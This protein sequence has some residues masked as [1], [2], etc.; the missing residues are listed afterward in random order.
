MSSPLSNPLRWTDLDLEPIY[1]LINRALAEDGTGLGLRK[2]QPSFF[3]PSTEMIGSTEKT[4]TASLVARQDLVVAGLPLISMVL[5]KV[6][7]FKGIPP[8]SFHVHLLAEDG[9][10]GYS[11]DLL[12]TLVGPAN[13]LLSGER[14][15]LNFLQ[16]LSGIATQTRLFVEAMGK[17]STRLLDTRKTTPG[18]RFLEK[19]AVGCGGGYNHRLGL[20]DRIMLKDNHLSAGQFASGDALEK[21]ILKARAQFPDLPVQVEV[22]NLSQIPPVLAAKVDFL[23]LDNFSDE[24]TRTALQL[25]QG[26]VPVELSGGITLP[27]LAAKAALGADFIST[28]ALVH[29]ATWPDIGLDWG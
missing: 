13:L 10:K 4:T 26:Q 20:F 16:H 27:D 28:G 8:S 1:Q 14:T 6:A 2:Q 29:Q 5:E 22:D 15:L 11:G 25:V 9:N 7:E 24:D 18:Y 21:A 19:Y 3:D 23:M 17:S 12:A